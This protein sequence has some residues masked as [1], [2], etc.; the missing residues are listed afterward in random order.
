MNKA[1]FLA[2]L[3]A[4]L[5]GLSEE[6]LRGSL[7]F[8]SE[9]I[10]DRM[11]AGMTEL[12]AVA[13]IGS[14]E[15]AAEQI[16]SEIPLQKLI[17]NKVEKRRRLETWEIILLVLGAPL[18]IPLLIAA[19]AVVFSV[20]VALLAVV[21]SIL[22]VVLAL[23]VSAVAVL[24]GGV[25]LFF[26]KSFF[27]ALMLLGAAVAIAGLCLLF[28]PVFKYAGKGVAVLLKKALMYIKHLF[29]K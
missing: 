21:F 14:V 6:D 20:F 7:D 11:E 1:E 2:A 17:R 15:Q 13:D 10:D 25:V 16:L 12:E 19:A 9:M 18:W 29:I 26:S 4:K 8:Y 28:Y 27:P 22:A 3:Q 5:S 24:V 23:G